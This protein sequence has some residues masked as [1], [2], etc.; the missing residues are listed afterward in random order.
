MQGFFNWL[1][2]WQTLSGAFLGTL[3]SV[4]IIFLTS[5]LHS[6]REIAVAAN[7]L[8]FDILPFRSYQKIEEIIKG[9]LGE[10]DINEEKLKKIVAESP[11]SKLS[12]LFYLNLERI[13]TVDTLLT[14]ALNIFRKS[15]E[16]IED[17]IKYLTKTKN[18]EEKQPLY[19][20]IM[21][22][23]KRASFCAEKA[24]PLLEKLRGKKMGKKEIQILKSFMKELEKI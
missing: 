15:I 10:D 20:A 12:P 13:G 22:G 6:K 23:L 1:H 17:H 11:K 4:I 24:C 8:L 9:K 7:A 21:K 19:Q 14:A 3:T 2:C 18:D 5:H 16:S